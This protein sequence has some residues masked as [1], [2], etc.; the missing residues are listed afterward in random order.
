MTHPFMSNAWFEAI[1]KIRDEIGELP[2]SEALQDVVINL[3]VTDGPDGNQEMHVRAGSFDRGLAENA[4][5]KLTMPYEV[6]RNLFIE[7]DPQTVRLV[8]IALVALFVFRGLAGFVSRYTMSWIGRRV[9][10]ELRRQ[11]FHRLLHLP[12]SHFDRNPSG[13]MLSRLT[14]DVEQVAEVAQG[15]SIT[16]GSGNDLAVALGIDRYPVLITPDGLRQ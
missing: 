8:P 4:P 11:V 9:I 2:T 5:T 12:A 3:V 10:Q 16:L 6:A 7:R 15:L 1:V 13:R 14:F